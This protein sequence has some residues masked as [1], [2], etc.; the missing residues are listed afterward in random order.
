MTVET[1]NLDTDLRLA[2]RFQRL[3]DR[4]SRPKFDKFGGQPMNGFKQ[5]LLRGNVIDMAVGIVV[6]A[7]FGTVVSAFVKDLLTPFIA[8]VVRKPDFSGIAFTLNSSKF[9]IGDFINQLIS[10]V[11]VA[12]A[13]YFAVV[14][15]MNKLISRLEPPASPTTKTCPECLSEIPIGAKRC[16]HCTSP[17]AA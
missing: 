2:Q 9:M 12:A 15:P 7:A 1:E 16:A 10:F 17:V 11:I 4:K 13:V 3:L 5:F 8:A 14:L 6:G